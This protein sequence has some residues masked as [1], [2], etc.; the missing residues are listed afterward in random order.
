MEWHSFSLAIATRLM[1][2]TSIHPEAQVD[3][4]FSYVKGKDAN[5]LNPDKALT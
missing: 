3:G 2:T 1:L 5:A 4:S